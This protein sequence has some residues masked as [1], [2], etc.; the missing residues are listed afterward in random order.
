MKLPLI[1]FGIW[2]SLLF[3]PV[4]AGEDKPSVSEEGFT[5]LF[6]GK[7]LSGWHIMNGGRFS[8]KEGVIFLDK[9]GG[10]LRS[11][12]TY[13]D[14]ELR[15][16]FR[17]L[18]KGANSGIFFRAN[19]DNGPNKAYQVQTMDGDSIGDIY[20]RSLAKPKVKRDVELVKKILK[21]TGEWQKYVITVREGT[22]EVRLNG[23]VVTKADGLATEAGYVGMQGEGGQL[24][25]KNVRIKTFE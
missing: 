5:S 20:D 21:P 8:V 19:D 17:F 12:K 2:A 23:E 4:W 22:V 1:V 14:F 25:F 18:N 10:W 7:D 6:N 24:E 16:D 3:A 11:D 9:G 13:R 15:M